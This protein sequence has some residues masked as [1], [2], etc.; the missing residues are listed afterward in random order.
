M[1]PE[2][3]PP[4]LLFKREKATVSAVSSV[5]ASM[6]AAAEYDGGSVSVTLNACP[7]EA[8]FPIV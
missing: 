6:H 2:R 4:G 3:P 5:H 7:S 1:R 8:R